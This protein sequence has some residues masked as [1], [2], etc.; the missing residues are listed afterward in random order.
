[1]LPVAYRPS[2][3]R[4]FSSRTCACSLVTTPPHVPT[5]AGNDPGG[6]ER[7]TVERPERGVRPVSGIAQT[8]LYAD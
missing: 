8:S 7:R 4:S 5:S 1:M 2:I 3:T 6:V